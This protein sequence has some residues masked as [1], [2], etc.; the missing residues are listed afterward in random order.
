MAPLK[1][2]T[3]EKFKRGSKN[4]PV[5]AEVIADALF[6]MTDDDGKERYF[7][8]IVSAHINDDFLK[9]TFKI[10]KG[11]GI[12]DTLGCT[13]TGIVK[14]TLKHAFQKLRVHLAAIDGMFTQEKIQHETDHPGQLIN[15]YSF[16]SDE[17]TNLFTITGIT[18]T[19]ADEDLQVQMNGTKYCSLISG[20]NKITTGKVLLANLSGYPWHEEMKA[21]IELC[22]LEASKYKMGNYI[23]VEEE[24][25]KT[26]KKGKVQKMK[27]ETSADDA[28]EKPDDAPSESDESETGAKVFVQK[29]SSMMPVEGEDSQEGFEDL[30]AASKKGKV[31]DDN[32]DFSEFT[33]A[34]L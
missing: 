26:A 32:D 1:K 9:Y 2:A 13:G 31:I 4:N 11:I 19:G 17:R 23:P 5:S 15:I 22:L 7:F 10:N 34:A 33:E 21:D 14:D 24:E 12:G 3:G 18:M 29:G 8:D 28:D 30:A 6:N 25:E 16:M 27:F 20:R